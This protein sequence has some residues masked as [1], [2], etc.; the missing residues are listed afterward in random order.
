[1]VVVGVMFFEVIF[2]GRIVMY[3]WASHR[4]LVPESCGDGCKK[5]AI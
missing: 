4:I 5:L 2:L 3:H 1:M